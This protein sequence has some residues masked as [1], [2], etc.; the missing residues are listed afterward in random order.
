MRL[1]HSSRDTRR[2]SKRHGEAVGQAF[3]VDVQNEAVTPATGSSGLGASSI[4]AVPICDVDAPHISRISDEEDFRFQPF[5]PRLEQQSD[6]RSANM[7]RQ[8][9]GSK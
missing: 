3:T 2:Q 1:R 9:C 4:R 8:S 5:D 6:W 7:L